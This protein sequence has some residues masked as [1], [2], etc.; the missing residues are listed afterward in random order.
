[1]NQPK[2]IN[3]ASD[4]HA[5]HVYPELG[6]PKSAKAVMVNIVLS[7]DEALNLARHLVQVAKELTIMSQAK[8]F[9]QAR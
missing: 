9:H 5:T 1:M 2:R 3:V 6:S 8:A 4:I 7:D